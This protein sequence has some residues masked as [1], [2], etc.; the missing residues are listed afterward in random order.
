MM[1]DLSYANIKVY[2]KYIK[3]IIS[4]KYKI[5]KYLNEHPVIPISTNLTRLYA[6]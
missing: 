6:N 2:L 5:M 4:G 3:G 1:C